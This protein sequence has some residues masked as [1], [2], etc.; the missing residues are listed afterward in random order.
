MKLP[1]GEA[2]KSFSFFEKIVNWLLET[3]IER[4]D[5]IIAFGGGVIGDLV[6][7][8]AS[9]TLRGVDFIQ[10]P[11]TLLSQVD[12]SVGGKT[13]INSSFGKNLIGSFHQPCLVLIDTE[14]LK[15]LSDRLLR[16]GY[17]EIVKYALINN[18][19]FFSWLEKNGHLILAGDKEALRHAIFVSCCSKAE[20][21]SNDERETGQR[22]LLNLGHTFGHAIESINQY[23]KNINHGEAVSIGIVFALKL[24]QELKHL[25]NKKVDNAIKHLKDIGLPTSLPKSIKKNTTLKKFVLAMKKDKK[26]KRGKINLI[27]L[28][29]IGKAFITNKFPEEKLNKVILSQLK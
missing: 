4:D 25:D 19:D 29:K 13:G 1:S 5:L 9:T 27:L 21:V 22:A 2:V 6:G 14:V 16:A 15:S 26:V 3:G 7:F 28:K 11:T 20:I 10:I 23:K 24:S 17:T 8:A 18:K 12:S